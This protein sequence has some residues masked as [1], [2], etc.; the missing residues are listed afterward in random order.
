MAVIFRCDEC[1]K[2][3]DKEKILLQRTKVKIPHKHTKKEREFLLMYYRCP[4][5]DHLYQCLPMDDVARDLHAQMD[6]LQE[7]IGRLNKRRAPVP[8]AI[9]NKA[10]RLKKELGTCYDRINRGYSGMPYQLGDESHVL[11]WIKIPGVTG[12]E[13]S[14]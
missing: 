7:R 2:N 12:E 4:H 9:R 5:C 3:F 14:Q 11:E 8:P 13:S 6:E 10:M 1:G